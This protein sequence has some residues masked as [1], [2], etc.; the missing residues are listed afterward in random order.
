MVFPAEYT[1]MPTREIKVEI[2]TERECKQ[3]NANAK[4]LA[5]NTRPKMR[6]PRNQRLKAICGG[7]IVISLQRFRF[8]KTCQSKTSVRDNDTFG[9]CQ[10]TFAFFFWCLSQTQT[11]S[12]PNASHQS[13]WSWLRWCKGRQGKCQGAVSQFQFWKGIYLCNVGFFRHCFKWD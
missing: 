8:L 4:W 6:L 3:R 12:V 13:S 5:W 2:L 9:S 10:T 1:R 7:R 11:G